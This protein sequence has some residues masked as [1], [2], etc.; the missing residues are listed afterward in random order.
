MQIAQDDHFSVTHRKPAERATDLRRN[1]GPLDQVRRVM[2]CS[3]PFE[4]DGFE[5]KATL[6]LPPSVAAEITG[7]AV[8]IGG[9]S[10]AR[11]IIARK[12]LYQSDE[13]FLRDVFG[14]I[15]TARHCPSKPIDDLLVSAIHE[16]ERL[17]FP[18]RGSSEQLVIG[19]LRM[20][21]FL[22][23][24]RVIGTS[25]CIRSAEMLGLFL[26]L[27]YDDGCVVAERFI[28]AE[29]PHVLEKAVERTAWMHEMLLKARQA[30][31]LKRRTGRLDDTV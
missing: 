27:K 15:R 22:S 4:T 12:L 8:E 13:Y 21:H 14:G 1:L 17:S 11:R 7:D 10:R 2:R 3:A 29:T 25:G 5:G 26:R 28:R 9:E 19:R 31:F 6:R 18:C 16:L 24:S 30:V 23:H 20:A